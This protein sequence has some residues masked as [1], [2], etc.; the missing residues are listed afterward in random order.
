MFF[1]CSTFAYAGAGNS[2]CEERISYTAG[3]TNGCKFHRSVNIIIA[4]HMLLP[5]AIAQ[6][7]CSLSVCHYRER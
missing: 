6:E 1:E 5:R 7:A 3:K 4:L 2:V